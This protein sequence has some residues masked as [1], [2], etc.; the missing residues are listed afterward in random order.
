MRNLSVLAMLPVLLIGCSRNENPEA[1]WKS[2]NGDYTIE[3]YGKDLGACCTSRMYADIISQGGA[4]DGLN[5]RLFE[6][7][8]GSDVQVNWTSPYHV[9]VR[10][11]NAK[12]ISYNSDFS[13]YD[14][15]RY[16][17]VSV[18]NTLPERTNGEVICPEPS[19]PTTPS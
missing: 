14:F 19:T 15:S 10:V 2:P 4:F 12:A 3:L 16:I 13:N 6:I 11:C 18:E 7:E 1:I 9:E 17:H 5:E 8:G